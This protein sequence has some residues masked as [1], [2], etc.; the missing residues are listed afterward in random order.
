M[1]PLFNWNVKQLFLYLTAEYETDNNV[2]I[3]FSICGCFCGKHFVTVQ[4]GLMK[5]SC[6]ITRCSGVKIVALGS[7]L[8]ITFSC[9]N[10]GPA[11]YT[12]IWLFTPS[13]V[14][15]S[16]Q[17]GV[18]QGKAISFTPLCLC[19]LEETKSRWSLLPG[20]YAR[21]SKRSHTGKRKKPVVD[22]LAL[23]Q[24]N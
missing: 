14:T 3:C 20:V 5:A 11:I 4:T 6:K 13:Q 21:G 24:G 15:G 16:N 8:A 22:S 10:S 2:S 9:Y 12:I 17:I 18:Q 23:E 7:N 1:N 19:L